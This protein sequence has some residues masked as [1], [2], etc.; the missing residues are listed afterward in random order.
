MGRVLRLGF[1]QRALA[2]RGFVGVLPRRAG[3]D[4][5]HR[6]LAHRTQLPAG[7]LGNRAGERRR[8][9]W[10]WLQFIA[11]PLA[12]TGVQPGAHA[13]IP[14]PS[15]PSVRN[16]WSARPRYPDA[17]GQSHFLECEP[18]PVVTWVSPTICHLEY[19]QNRRV[20]SNRRAGVSLLGLRQRRPAQTGSL[21]RSD[22]E[23]RRRQRTSRMS[24]PSL[25]NAPFTG[26]ARLARDRAL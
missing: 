2:P 3:V 6:R 23:M 5:Q 24:R 25:C 16:Y 12:E 26:L 11:G 7:R 1:G 19:E 14:G 22:I 13:E 8:A 4:P 10:A 18:D 15:V 17:P 9:G 21:R 20:G